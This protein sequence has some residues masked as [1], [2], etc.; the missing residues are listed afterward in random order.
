MRDR[1]IEVIAIIIVIIALL[2]TWLSLN[3]N[4][5]EFIEIGNYSLVTNTSDLVIAKE[6]KIE[7]IKVNSNI[8]YFY[9]EDNKLVT[10]TG[11]INEIS[12]TKQNI[13]TYK[14]KSN[15]TE[16]SIDSSCIIGNHIIS[17]PILGSILGFAIT[18]DGFL[19]LI[20]LP[21]LI[22]CIYELFKFIDGV[23]KK[24]TKI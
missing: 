5:L 8:V 12:N 7:D 11:T 19:L 16:N 2:I 10:K 9:Y 17:I 22:I 13:K 1:I 14:V 15:N 4:N 24:K 3:I 6:N 21:L 20:V 23:E 18:R